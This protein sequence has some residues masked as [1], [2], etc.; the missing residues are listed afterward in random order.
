LNKELAEKKKT[1]IKEQ[2]DLNERLGKIEQ[3]L[4]NL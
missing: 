3:N 4:K 1:L 2:K